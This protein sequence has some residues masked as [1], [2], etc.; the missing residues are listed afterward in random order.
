VEDAA[1]ERVLYEDLSDLEAVVI[2][3]DVVCSGGD[4]LRS[5][6][7]LLNPVPLEIEDSPFGN[8]FFCDVATEEENVVFFSV[9]ERPL[10]FDRRVPRGEEIPS[11]GLEILDTGGRELNGTD[12]VVEEVIAVLLLLLLLLLFLL[13]LLL[14]VVVI[15]V[16]VVGLD[17]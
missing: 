7:S 2:D 10:R 12:D 11:S 3:V 15:V 1:R 9:D 16:V 17:E 14:E 5:A 4:K 8:I 6:K 13:L